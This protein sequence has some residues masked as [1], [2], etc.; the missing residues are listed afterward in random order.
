MTNSAHEETLRDAH[1]WDVMMTSG[2]LFPEVQPKTIREIT[3][4]VLLLSGAKS[5]PFLKLISQELKRL[6]PNHDAIVLPDAGHQM[7][8][9]APDVCRREVQA[10][11]GRIGIKSRLTSGRG[12]IGSF[13]LED[14]IVELA[15]PGMSR[16]EATA[17]A[18]REFGSLS[19][20]RKQ[21][22]GA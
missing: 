5:F 1:E 7:R 10:F 21:A 16:A 22:R 19:L 11:L 3:V 6:L 8:Y 18:H 4:P 15:P 14:R 9:Q 2:T 17:A 12:Q 20:M 13:H